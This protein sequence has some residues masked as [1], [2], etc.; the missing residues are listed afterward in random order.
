VFVVDKDSKAEYRPVKLGP[1]VDGLRVVKDG[2]KA[3]ESIVVNGLQRVRPGAPLVPQVVP[4]DVDNRKTDKVA[5]LDRT[6][7]TASATGNKE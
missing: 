4:M 5:V 1:T 3:G 6:G 7:N 2:L